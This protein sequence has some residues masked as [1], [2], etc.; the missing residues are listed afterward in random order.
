MSSKVQESAH[1]LNLSLLFFQ[2]SNFEETDLALRMH[3]QF[4]SSKENITIAKVI[5]G[6]KVPHGNLLQFTL[7]VQDPKCSEDRPS[8]AVLE[9][10][11]RVMTGLFVFQ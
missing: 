1:T 10:I 6:S 3:L 8:P 11:G 2:N 7:S 5:I 4:R 9:F